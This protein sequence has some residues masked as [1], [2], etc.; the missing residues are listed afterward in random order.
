MAISTRRNLVLWRHAE[1]EDV[2][3]ASNDFSRRLTTKGESQ[4]AIMAS[5]LKRHLPRDTAIICSPAVR[6]EQTAQA[7]RLPY[8]INHHLL[9]EASISEVL[10][11]VNELIN[12]SNTHDV[13]LVGH[14]PWLGQVAAYFLQGSLSGVS[15]KKSAVWWLEQDLKS[16][17]KFNSNEE[18]RRFK[19]VAVQSPRFIID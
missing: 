18:N 1:A 4:V 10:E 13:L 7:L 9:P 8:Q 6:A 19:L 11:F 15:I 14:Q 5:W 17:C 2:L 3:S 16:G 12:N